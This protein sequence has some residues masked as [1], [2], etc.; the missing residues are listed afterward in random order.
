MIEV[1]LDTAHLS[2]DQSLV[3][4]DDY[5]KRNEV[6]E[7]I[8]TSADSSPH[9]TKNGGRFCEVVL[10]RWT[11]ELRSPDGHTSAEL[12][13]QLPNVYKKGVVLFRSL[14]TF[15]RFLPAWRLYRK[16]GRQAGNQH[17][18]RLK[19]RIRQRQGLAIGQKDT[20]YTPLCQTDREGDE[21]VEHYPFQPL[22][23]PAG[24]LH[25]FVEYRTNC[26][27]GVA[28]Q[29][30]LLSSRFLSVDEGLPTLPTGGSLPGARIDRTRERYSSTAVPT[31]TTRERPRGLLGAYG[32]LGTFHQSDKRGSPVSG[33]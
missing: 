11:V 14:Y 25:C 7:A 16:L 22:M 17:A 10:E 24:P 29:E 19:F 6:A 31:T 21:I 4:V 32:S 5:G 33:T 8:G 12:N 13:D 28:D 23:T 1:Y 18:L 26:E 2:R 3:I 20:L 9:P 27:F 30:A 15:L